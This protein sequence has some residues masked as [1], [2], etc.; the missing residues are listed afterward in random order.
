MANIGSDATYHRERRER[1]HEADAVVV[2][3]GIFG[4]AMAYALA[5]QGRSVILLERWMHEPDRIVGELLQPGGCAALRKLGLGHCLEGIDAVPCYGYHIL[6]HGEEVNFPYPAL[7]EQGE[8][9]PAAARRPGDD[10]KT[11]E[12]R[13][14]HHGRF[15]MQ[16][17]K[18]CQAH[19]SISVFETEV[20]ATVKGDNGPEILGV[21]T[22]TTDPKTGEKQPDCFFGKLTI[23]ADGYASKFRKQLLHITPQVKSRFYALELKDCPIS[24]SGYGHV[25]IGKASPVLLYA[26]G[27]RETRTLIDVPLDHPEAAPDKGG[28]RGY[29]RNVV[30]PTLP[31]EV[32]PSFEA[33]LA[34]GKIPR[35]M[36]NSWLP[37][38]KQKSNPPG[39]LILG[40]AMNMRHPLT[41]GGMTVAFNDVVLL[42]GLLEDVKDLDDHKALGRVMHTFYWRRKPLSSII[43]VLAM[44][45]YSLF[46]ADSKELRA[47]RIGCFTYFKKGITE[48]PTGLLGGLIHRPWVLFRHF[49]TVAFLAIYLH[50]CDV[51]GS[52][53][54][55]GIFKLPIAAVE[56]VLILWKACVVF[57]P[58]LYQEAL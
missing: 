32:V 8:V 23:I 40:D 25:N 2:G 42:S 7:D 38:S 36:P 20:T 39:V 35:S 47:L 45:L 37:P 54:V 50:A 48:E 56:G 26:I 11:P 17:R 22:R 44:A 41:G 29:I 13:G 34:D 5:Q 9:V 6:F 21:E 3:A 31:R 43:N 46:A 24:P 10:Y 19:P 28:V 53:G 12:G 49:F 18:S 57:L 33:A 16:L 4:C 14:F 52:A 55:L 15:I 27:S 51:V 58:I 30:L 1:H